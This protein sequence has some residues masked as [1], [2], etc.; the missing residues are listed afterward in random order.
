MSC[1]AKVF[2]LALIVSSAASSCESGS[3]PDQTSLMQLKKI[4]KHGSERASTAPA[5][6]ADS[7]GDEQVDQKSAVEQGL[8]HPCDGG[9]VGFV[10]AQ[11]MEAGIAVASCK[12]PTRMELKRGER[13][14]LTYAI[15]THAPDLRNDWAFFYC[16]APGL[17]YVTGT[18]FD[19]LLP[20]QPV[21]SKFVSDGKAAGIQASVAEQGYY[22]IG[23]GR[24]GCGASDLP[25]CELGKLVTLN[26][27]GTVQA[28]KL[29]APILIKITKAAKYPIKYPGHGWM[30]TQLLTGAED[31]EVNFNCKMGVLSAAERA[32]NC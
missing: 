18:A 31:T 32:A 4:V 28:L 29:A 9:V 11:C 6:N 27:H 30:D 10:G 7:Y 21:V 23:F 3:C 26:H 25:S 2:V 20:N 15:S 1:L 24:S 5:E 17:G 22:T 14:P 13:Q 16:P 12:G 19:G 8:L